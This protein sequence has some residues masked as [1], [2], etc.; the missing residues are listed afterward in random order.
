MREKNIKRSLNLDRSRLKKDSPDI[1][2]VWKELQNINK[3][4]EKAFDQKVEKVKTRL[5]KLKIKTP[6]KTIVTS[7][8]KTPKNP[9][10]STV[11]IK[12]QFQKK[13]VRLTVGLSAVIIGLLV[14][15]SIGHDDKTDQLGAKIDIK[16]QQSSGDIATDIS[17]VETTEFSL[18]WPNGKSEKDFKIVRVSPAGNEP[19]YT[20]IDSLNNQDIK[21]SQQEVPDSF[22]TERDIKLKELADSFQATNVIQI[23]DNKIY[24]GFSEKVKTQSLIFIKK[25]LL[26]FIASP[27]QN[28]DEVWAGYITG[29]K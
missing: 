16:T 4:E 11:K 12:K 10:K 17:N 23:D 29:L 24:H 3:R 7:A 1:G 28:S 22:K 21:I 27:Q 8:K 19:V 9:K 6:S 15:K 14:V 2:D 20:Y 25:D 26:I 18:L 13:Q 5:K